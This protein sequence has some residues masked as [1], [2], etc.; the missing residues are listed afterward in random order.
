MRGAG[1]TEGGI[2]QF[3][4]GAAMLVGGMYLLLDAI[5]VNTSFAWGARLFGVGG[6]GITGGMLL[7][8]FVFGV[9]LIFFDARSLPGWLLALGSI[10]ALVFGVLASV[11]F[12]LRGMSAFDLLVILVLAV[13]GLGLLL[14]S[15][16]PARAAA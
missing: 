9:G 10:L 16:R 12:S 2:G 14:R 4:V 11:S 6:T 1:G 13:G 7:I 8:P 5:A 3:L 15:L